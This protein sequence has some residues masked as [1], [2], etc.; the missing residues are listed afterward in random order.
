[1]LWGLSI[2][3]SLCS[4][5]G[6]P[7][8]S[9]QGHSGKSGRLT[10]SLSSCHMGEK[11]SFLYLIQ[12]GGCFTFLS[13]NSLIPVL[14]H[15]DMTLQVSFFPCLSNGAV[16]PPFRF[17][18]FTAVEHLLRW[19]AFQISHHKPPDHL[20]FSFLPSLSG[21]LAFCR[22]FLPLRTSQSAFT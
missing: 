6:L 9:P 18:R 2:G 11:G 17:Q 22:S 7:L 19:S 10:A 14:R 20:H 15:H 21:C 12:T 8:G 1:M 5:G 13:T 3:H 16:S 4:W